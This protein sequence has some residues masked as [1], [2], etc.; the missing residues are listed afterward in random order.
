MLYLSRSKED[1]GGLHGHFRVSGG[2]QKK[3]GGH[4]KIQEVFKELLEISD[5]IKRSQGV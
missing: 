4:R 5:V 1:T 2:I 3:S